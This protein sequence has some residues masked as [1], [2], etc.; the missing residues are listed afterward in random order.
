MKRILIYTDELCHQLPFTNTPQYHYEFRSFPGQTLDSLVYSQ[1]VIPLS[2]DLREQHYHA[3]IICLGQNDLDRHRSQESVVRNL[4][5]LHDICRRHNVRQIIGLFLDSR[6][7]REFNHLYELMSG[8][9]IYFCN[10]F[11]DLRWENFRSDGQHMNLAGQL[12]LVQSL[13]RLIR[14]DLNPPNLYGAFPT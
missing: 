11:M 4:L 1:E 2:S 10:Y 5:Q 8:D 9:D 13:N 7:Y 3:V 6:R 12:R 14:G